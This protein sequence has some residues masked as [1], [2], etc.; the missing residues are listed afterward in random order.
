MK[1]IKREIQKSL[2]N[3]FRYLMDD[4]KLMRDID[5]THFEEEFKLSTAPVIKKDSSAPDGTQLGI[6]NGTGTIRYCS[7]SS[8]VRCR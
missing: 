8:T 2:G 6:S 3:F 4:D 5:F 1:S 7:I